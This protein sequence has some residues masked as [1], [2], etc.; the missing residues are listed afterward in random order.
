MNKE[1]MIAKALGEYDGKM[2]MIREASEEMFRNLP[3]NVAGET[4]AEA[5]RDLNNWVERKK[6]AAADAL[7]EAIKKAD[8]M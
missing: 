3:V 2:A 7:V 8:K 4:D 6:A 1:I 5:L